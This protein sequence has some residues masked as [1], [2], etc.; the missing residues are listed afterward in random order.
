MLP[1]LHILLESNIPELHHELKEDV[2]RFVE[3]AEQS[4]DMTYIT[5][6]Y[7]GE[8]YNFKE[9]LF[10]GK[11]EN[12][13]EMLD[14]LKEFGKEQNFEESFINNLAVV[15]DELISNIIKYGYKEEQGKIYLRLLY[16]LD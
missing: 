12:I 14:F 7:H 13:P 11:E 2:E 6:K 5:L 3:G 1:L 8:K 15:G 16:N 4:D 10:P 9:R